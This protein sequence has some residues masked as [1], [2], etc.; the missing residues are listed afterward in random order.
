MLRV[1]VLPFDDRGNAVARVFVRPSAAIRRTC[2]RAL[3]LGLLL[4]VTTSCGR[5]DGKPKRSPAASVKSCTACYESP[6][7]VEGK[8]QCT[9]HAS[10]DAR[11][12]AAP[13]IVDGACCAVD[14][15]RA[16]TSATAWPACK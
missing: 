10:G 2:M 12:P 6:S 8:K 16:T 14:C 11:L 9:V 5:D 4:V 3:I 13:I 15:C 7:R 1:H